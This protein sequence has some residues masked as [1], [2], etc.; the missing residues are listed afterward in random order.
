MR[1]LTTSMFLVSSIAA[2]SAWTSGCRLPEEDDY[3]RSDAGFD[4]S[5]DDDAGP[6]AVC[7][8]GAE[9]LFNNAYSPYQ[10]GEESVLLDVV[11]F[12]FFKCPHCANF[13]QT[14]EQIWAD[15]PEFRAHVRVY[16]HHFPFDYQSAWDVHAATVAAGNQGMENFWALHDFLFDGIIN[17]GVTYSLDEIR[18]YCE[19]TLLLEMTQ[20]EEDLADPYTYGFLEWDKEQAQAVGVTGTPSVFICGEKIDW[21]DLESI[22]AGYLGL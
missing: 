20:F 2:A 9:D 12:S 17:E 8:E 13:A 1:R 10:G 14:W 7:P 16:F 11:D 19:G 22:V 21:G 6:G 4:A 18:A 5:V 3:D 15:N